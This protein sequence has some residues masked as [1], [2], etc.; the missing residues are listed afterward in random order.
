VLTCFRVQ[1]LGFEIWGLRFRVRVCGLGFRVSV[2]LVWV[3]DF[4]VR[5]LVFRV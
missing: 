4:G 2:V 3:L 1:C 5:G